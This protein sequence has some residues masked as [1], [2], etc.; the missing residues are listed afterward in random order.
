MARGTAKRRPVWTVMALA[1]V[2]S[3][4]IMVTQSCKGSQ[5]PIRD[6][7][8]Q[9]ESIEDIPVEDL[10]ESQEFREYL[11]SAEPPMTLGTF[12]HLG[13]T[14]II[15]A[16]AQHLIYTQDAD[17]PSVVL[18]DAMGFDLVISY[19][20]GGCPSTLDVGRTDDLLH[21]TIDRT[22]GRGDTCPSISIPHVKG[23]Q[24]EQ[25]NR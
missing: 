25:Q 20:V 9:V 23:I 10:W 13:C 12:A 1:A 19:T 8:G 16:D 22:I 21:F 15:D 4:A 11:F 5:R 14:Q 18:G 7:E 2:L 24:L 17:C 6:P 3:I